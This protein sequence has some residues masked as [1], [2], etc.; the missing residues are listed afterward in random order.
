MKFKI[1]A[2]LLACFLL[3]AS[4]TACNKDKPSDETGDDIPLLTPATSTTASPDPDETEEPDE[5]E[6][7]A[8]TTAATTEATTEATTTAATTT[9]APPPATT[10][11]EEIKFTACDETVYVIASA[12]N[13]RT[14]PA[15][16][17]NNIATQVSEGQAIQRTGYHETWSRVVIEGKEYYASSKYL[18]T[19]N[20]NAEVIFTTR[21]ETVY[22]TAEHLYIRETPSTVG[23]I[24]D[25]ATKGT[26]LIRIGFNEDWSKV[27]FDN[28]ILYCS[29]HYL[30]TENPNA[31]A[32]TAAT[33]TAA[34]AQ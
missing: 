28:K 33:T 14:S 2:A 25:A 10:A 13:L 23:K 26:E 6:D 17:D 12:L 8:A 19:E 32:T 20:P 11:P 22:V 24:Y 30:S 31:A 9:T 4:L 18:S 7:P 1:T 29:S 15:V 27:M 3:L 34:P 16:E 21:Y 5:T